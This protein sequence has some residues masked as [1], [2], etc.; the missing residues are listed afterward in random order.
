M[1]SVSSLELRHLTLPAF[2]AIDFDMLQA[3]VSTYLRR[4]FKRL[5]TFPSWME[6]DVHH[7]RTTR[8]GLAA[9]IL[10]HSVG[11]GVI[12][13]AGLCH[14]QQDSTLP[15][16]LACHCHDGVVIG[17]LDSVSDALR[18]RGCKGMSVLAQCTC[19]PRTPPGSCF[20][21]MWKTLVINKVQRKRPGLVSLDEKKRAN[22]VYTH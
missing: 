18:R 2:S 13:T 1:E 22:Q 9:T 5:V 8:A 11:I 19:N 4:P 14:T 7:I 12:C 3:R 6:L 16:S 20:Y 17:S 15:I 10:K 21:L